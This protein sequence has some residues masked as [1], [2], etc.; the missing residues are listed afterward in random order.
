MSQKI[1]LGLVFWLFYTS[2]QAFECDG[3]IFQVEFNSN[4][5]FASILKDRNILANL[6]CTFSRDSDTQ[7]KLIS[8]R[9]FNLADSGYELVPLG[10][11][12]FRLYALSFAGKKQLD[13]ILCN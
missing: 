1:T 3:A 2:I 7:E 5:E 9:D 11:K 8:C 12:I 10:A 13:V 6:P 4:L